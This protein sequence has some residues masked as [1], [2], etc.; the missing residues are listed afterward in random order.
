MVRTSNAR[1][2]GITLTAVILA[3]SGLA[4]LPYL[5]QGN[6]SPDAADYLNIAC[7]VA[8]GRGL[9]HTIKWHFFTSDEVRHSAIG[10]RPLLYPLLLVPLCGGVYPARAAQY[11]TL[12]FAAAAVALGAAWAQRMGYGWLA[13]VICAGLLAF[14]PGL[15]M[16]SVYPSTEPLYLCWL[17]TILLVVGRNA[18]SHRV[19]CLA[20]LLTALA[21]L[22]RPSAPMIAVALCLWYAH[23]RAFSTLVCYL[24]TLAVFLV[25]WWAIVWVVR[26]NP[27]YSL[28]NFHLVVRDI[29]EGMAAGY[30]VTFPGSIEF[31]S[32]HAWEVTVKAGKQTF[33]YL[34]QLLGPTYFSVLA[35]ALFL[36]PFRP[37]EGEARTDGPCFAIALVHFALPAV[38]WATFDT[39]R[40]MLPCFAILLAPVVAEMCHLV[41]QLPMKRARVA[42]WSLILA[43]IGLFYAD[44][45]AQLY[46]RVTSRRTVDQAM[47]VARIEFDRMVEQEA[48]VACKDPFSISYYFDRPAVVLPDLAKRRDQLRRFLEEYRPSYIVVQPEDIQ[49][50]SALAADGWIHPVGWL[51]SVQLE[52]LRVTTPAP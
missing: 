19:A 17:F 29:T 5:E 37:L 10:E 15:L 8:R 4:R 11:A 47:Q 42:A 43:A 48:V 44:Q 23:R 3:L 45:W 46:E 20:G 16:Y 12:L 35:V 32:A 7:N 6:L 39:A 25:P 9:V 2:H 27:F 31:L 36:R 49:A 30:G 13:V 40:F 41:G 14:N 51:G 26:G 22:T 38:T 21:Y 33:G 24:L 28:Q 50:V 18:R 52:V 1:W 34:L